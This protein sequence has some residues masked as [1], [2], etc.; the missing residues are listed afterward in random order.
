[1]ATS[2]GAL[3]PEP[4]AKG[5]AFSAGLSWAARSAGAAADATMS[6]ARYNSWQKGAPLPWF[7]GDVMPPYFPVPIYQVPQATGAAASPVPPTLRK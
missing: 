1:M 6:S 7:Y 5:G 4:L 3:T 2:V